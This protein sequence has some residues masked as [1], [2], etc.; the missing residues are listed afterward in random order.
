MMFV[1]DTNVLSE[2]MRARGAMAVVEW[3]NALPPSDLFTTALNQAEILYGL[4]IMPKGRKRA[5][6]I[7][8][9]DEMFADD[10]RGRILPF[11]E[12][13]AGHYADIA[14]TRERLGRPIQP[15]DAQIAGIARAHGMTV[16]TRDV[17]DF[18][19]CGINVVNPWAS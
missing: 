4:A 14:A 10:F 16:V 3:T 9:A 8:R 15:V 11:D 17:G 19:G 13:A 2:L 5:D 12:R 18:A 6:R 7:M 1:L